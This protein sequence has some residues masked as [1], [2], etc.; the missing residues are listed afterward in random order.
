MALGAIRGKPSRQEHSFIVDDLNIIAVGSR[1]EACFISRHRLFHLLARF[2]VTFLTRHSAR[3]LH[4]LIEGP[5][6]ASKRLAEYLE[7]M[8]F[9]H[10]EEAGEAK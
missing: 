9:E 4:P 8:L 6:P 7:A 2:G 10:A 3:A 5:R 1:R